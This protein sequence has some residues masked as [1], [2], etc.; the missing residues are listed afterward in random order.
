MGIKST[1]GK[2]TQIKKLV[3]I[4][5]SIVAALTICPVPPAQA[6][7]AEGKYPYTIFAGSGAEGAVTIE[8][9]NFCLNGNLATNG[10][11]AVSDNANINGNR[12]EHAGEK[13]LYIFDK[14]KST[15]FTE[16]TIDVHSGDYVLEKDNIHISAPLAV[17]G[18]TTLTGNVHISSAVMSCGDIILNGEVK[19]AEDSVIFSQYGSIIIDSVNVNLNGLIYA[20]FGSVDISAQNLN[21]NHVIIIADKITLHCSSVNANYSSKMAEYIGT[22]TEW[23]QIPI[24]E[25]ENL[26]DTDKDGLPDAVEQELGCDPD[27]PDTDGDGLPDG[28]E[29]LT[30][31]TSP[32]DSDTDANGVSDAEEDFDE[33][34][35]TNIDEYNHSTYPWISDTDDDA[36]LD[37][38]E[39]HRYQTDP[40]VAD[41]DGDGLEDG[42]EIILGFHPLVKD[43]DGNGVIDS[44]EMIMQSYTYQVENDACAVQEIILKMQ[45]TGNLAETTDIESVMGTDILSSDVSGLVG[46]PF[47]INTDS[48]F[49]SC[50]LS[51]RVDTELLGETAIEDLAV[52]WYDK[53]NQEYVM[54]DTVCDAQQALVTATVTHFSTYMIVDKKEWFRYWSKELNYTNNPNEVS[55]VHTVLAVDCSSSMST[56]DPITIV[57][58]SGYPYYPI[59]RCERY[60]AT[61]NYIDAMDSN[62]MAA[63]VTFNGTARVVSGLTNNKADLTKAV[64]Q[65]DNSGGTS[66]TEAVKTS[67]HILKDSGGA[68]RKIILLTDGES[69]ISDALLTQ[70]KNAGVKIYTVGFGKADAAVLKRIAEKTGGEYFIAANAKQ[71]SKIYEELGADYDKTD[72][73][74]DGL[75]DIIE[76]TGIRLANGRII[77]TDPGKKDTDGDGLTDGQE[78]NPKIKRYKYTTYEGKKYTYYFEMKSDPTKKDSDGDSYSD[79]DEVKKYASFPLVNEVKKY[80]WNQEFFSVDCEDGKSSYGGNQNWVPYARPGTRAYDINNWGCGLVSGSDILLYL[81]KQDYKY[82]T[83]LTRAVKKNSAKLYD[84]DSY[85]DYL[86]AMDKKYL[87]VRGN[88]GVLGNFLA[89]GINAY[90]RDYDL[91]LKATWCT[92][93]KKMYKRIIEMLKADIPV[94]LSMGPIK[95]EKNGVVFCNWDKSFKG[96]K[97]KFV[98]RKGKL[99]SSH[100]VTVTGILE[101]GV[102][103]ETMLEISSWGTKYY[104]NYDEYLYF[105]EKY[106]NPVFSNIMYIEKK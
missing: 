32:V 94:T 77:Y 56:Y 99:V 86:Y 43:T 95:E 105:I 61:A 1:V 98:P 20:P 64:S 3:C 83:A 68:R 67:L 71:L 60:Q 58:P 74:G 103:G 59:N 6:A 29:V 11:I 82:T 18:E 106:S 80:H 46:E 17:A 12:Q 51:F 76:K 79:Y 36:L 15:Y 22:E 48:A 57:K 91:K 101:N 5:L 16:G 35:L 30:L 26:P 13:M 54:L 93:K 97:Y 34:G 88:L 14:I 2:S 85:M 27:K 55:R 90:G 41:T 81:A 84:K 39:V 63:V 69:Y 92:S 53:D 50:E 23:E 75:P 78:I 7:E 38:E 4:I 24:E 42:D 25:Y 40:L 31:D 49:A 8:A 33:D 70:A 102:K 19:N 89:S 72:T 44:E 45:A 37:G 73:D 10:T 65:F 52:L 104:I 47:E 87:R 21:L 28:Y 66:F 100:Y 96:D 9:E 62:D